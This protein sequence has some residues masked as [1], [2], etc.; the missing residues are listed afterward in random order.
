MIDPLKKL[1]GRLHKPEDSRTPPPERVFLQFL[2]RTLPPER[3]KHVLGVARLAHELAQIHGEE[4]ER[5]RLAGL[6]HD[7]ARCW[8]G[9]RL[10]EYVRRYRIKVPHTDFV[11]RHQPVIFHAYVGAD[12]A[13]RLFGVRDREILSAIAKHTMADERMTRLEKI[14]YLADHLS[15][16]RVFTEA[17]PLRRLAREDLDAAFVE[18]LRNKMIYAVMKDHPIHPHAARVWNLHRKRAKA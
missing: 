13:R 6:L 2:R 7:T 15:P 17:G 4:P 16:D 10:A 1:F 3:Y 8:S 5:A 12:L 11:R 14:V 18:A 9:R